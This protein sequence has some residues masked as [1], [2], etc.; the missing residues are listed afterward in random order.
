MSFLEQKKNQTYS[1]FVSLNSVFK[2]ATIFIVNWTFHISAKKLLTYWLWS[3]NYQAKL[4]ATLWKSLILHIF[5]KAS[6]ATVI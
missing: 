1:Y 2:D 6:C 4:F 5:S 3:S